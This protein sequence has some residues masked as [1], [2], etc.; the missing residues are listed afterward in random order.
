MR[1]IQPYFMPAEPDV[2]DRRG[3]SSH[4][5][6]RAKRRGKL[7]SFSDVSIGAFAHP[8]PFWIAGTI[9]WAVG[10]TGSH[11][12][13][14]KLGS[15]DFAVHGGATI[16]TVVRA[17]NP[18]PQL[19]TV[20][21]GKVLN[22]PAAGSARN[23]DDGELNFR[24]GQPVSSVLKGWLSV[25]ANY[26][27]Y[28]V[29]V[30]GKGWTDYTLENSP[31]PWGNYPNGLISNTPLSDNGFESRAKFSGL[32]LQE[33][34]VYGRAGSNFDFR[35][36][37]QTINWGIPF[38]I[39]GG[40]SALNPFDFPAARRAGSVGEELT[41]PVPSSTFKFAAT[42]KLTVEGFWQ[43]AQARN[44]YDG[45]GTFYASDFFGQGCNY[46][47]TGGPFVVPDPAFFPLGDFINRAATPKNNELKQGGIGARYAV[48][49]LHT[50]VGVYYAHYNSRYATT[51]VSRTFRT[52][53]AI[54]FIAGNPDEGNPLF[55]TVFAPDIDMLAANFR[56]KLAAKT[57]LSGEYVYR[58]N[59]PLA[60]PAGELLTAAVSASAPSLFR[61]DLDAAGPG[62]FYQGYDRHQTG[63]LNV[64]VSQNFEDVGGAKLVVLTGEIALRQVYG[65]PDPAVRRY[66]RSDTFGNGPV[67]GVCPVPNPGV[68]YT[69]C[70]L[71][72][73][74]TSNA[75]G[76]RLGS[77]LSYEIGRV[78]GLN[79]LISGSYG[80]DVS[81]WSYDGN[82]NEGRNVA[83]VKVRAEYKR[84]YYVEVAFAPVWGGAF[85]AQRDRSIYLA[86]MGARF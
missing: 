39:A 44:A 42:P 45:C 54:P 57:T 17:D 26:N 72:G 8:M 31:V 14:F 74:V 69:G 84:N 25:D 32:A 62:A 73:F 61:A 52:S 15:L 79:L 2:A 24:K 76:F 77:T 23:S 1:C 38:A 13:E 67:N 34:Y 58:P 70:T 29:Y 47:L 30:R 22:V 66:A 43:F 83:S 21:N 37:D 36:G 53:A 20:P 51:E 86:S 63:A 48:D 85:Y 65:L 80:R 6:V 19:V 78:P 56:T 28:G 46:A 82:L 50:D 33:A 4:V 16:G 3:C 9:L 49:A 11:A 55:R 59:Q 68:T 10:P 40:I 81:G 35:I 27:N 5:R 12:G 71:D 60:L 75:W 64:G 41:I 18:D 7:T